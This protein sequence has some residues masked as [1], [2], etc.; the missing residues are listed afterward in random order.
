V[1]GGD[2]AATLAEYAVNPLGLLG[3]PVWPVT[4]TGNAFHSVGTLSRQDL[5]MSISF[6]RGLRQTVER[7]RQARERGA[8]CVG[9]CDNYV[10]PLAREC[11]E[12]FLASIEST[13]LGASY[14]APV[15]LFNLI[16]AACCR[17]RQARTLA[18]VRELDQEQRKGSR[19][20]NT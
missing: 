15:S 10:S 18:I 5:V 20:Y 2:L 9:V 13:S 17:F 11:H 3:L 7:T 1:L 4:S 16:L 12:V 6:R 19:W 8:Y 14:S